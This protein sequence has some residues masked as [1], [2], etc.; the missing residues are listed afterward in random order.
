MLRICDIEMA[1]NQATQDAKVYETDMQ[2]WYDS[3]QDCY[4]EIRDDA[5]DNRKHNG[6]WRLTFEVDKHGNETIY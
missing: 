4:Y 5:V 3:D 6:Q 2:V 1:I